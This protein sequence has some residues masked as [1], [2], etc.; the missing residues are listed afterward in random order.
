MN[1]FKSDLSKWKSFGQNVMVSS[2]LDVTLAQLWK[3]EEQNADD[4]VEGVEG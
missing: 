2:A 3:S 4:D 1:I